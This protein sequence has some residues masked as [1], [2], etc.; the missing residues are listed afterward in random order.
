[1]KLFGIKTPA[2]N[3]FWIAEDQYRSWCLFFKEYPNRP[4]ISEAIK[5]YESIGYRCVEV[6]VIEK[7]NK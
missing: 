4:T 1:M 7:I 6:E 2:D 3:I 5:A